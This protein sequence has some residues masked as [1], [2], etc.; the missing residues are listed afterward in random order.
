MP[1]KKGRGR[2]PTGKHAARRQKKN[3]TQK[4]TK[5][6][7]STNA[8]NHDN[9]T[10]TRQSDRDIRIGNS[11]LT[12]SNA[13]ITP[14]YG[15]QGSLSTIQIAN[16][17]NG[18]IKLQQSA[19]IYNHWLAH[20]N[21]GEHYFTGLDGVIT[22]RDL[23]R[24]CFHY[25][26]SFVQFI[27]RNK[28]SIQV[29]IDQFTQQLKTLETAGFNLA[30]VIGDPDTP[31]QELVKNQWFNM[32]DIINYFKHF[33]KWAKLHLQNEMFIGFKIV[34]YYLVGVSIEAVGERAD[35]CV[36]FKRVIEFGDILNQYAQRNNQ[37]RTY[38]N[39]YCV[40][41]AKSRKN[42][43]EITDGKYG[44]DVR[45]NRARHWENLEY[46]DE[47]EQKIEM[48]FSEQMQNVSK[49]IDPTKSKYVTN[50]VIAFHQDQENDGDQNNHDHSH[51]LLVATNVEDFGRG[52]DNFIV[53]KGK[54]ALR[55]CENCSHLGIMQDLCQQCR[56]VR[57]CSRAC[58]KLHWE[59]HKKTCGKR[60]K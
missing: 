5:S 53:S 29:L 21:L 44:T 54:N 31:R 6:K 28:Y 36:Q 25:Y 16:N 35:A 8:T 58:Q 1:R 59:T 42:R 19:T 50:T 11:L 56:K 40:N 47:K 39:Q 13:L 52:M 18:F 37:A 4:S 12:L 10:I 60:A 34:Y 57:Y 7:T 14:K 45:L 22:K 51:G 26:Q 32:D 38:Y 23:I 33:L 48:E 27:N 43:F 55:K 46:H 2:K 3:S 15:Y 20:F 9:Q 49:N 41:E 30:N 24:S 17:K